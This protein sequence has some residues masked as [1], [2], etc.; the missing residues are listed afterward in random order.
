VG[1]GVANGF[2]RDTV[3]GQAPAVGRR[4]KPGTV[5]MLGTGSMLVLP[6]AVY[7]PYG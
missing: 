4:V 5:V 3:E 7:D 2:V 1:A 6:R